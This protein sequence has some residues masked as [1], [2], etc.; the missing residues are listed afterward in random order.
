[1]IKQ[2]NILA[3]LCFILLSG[4]S[5]AKRLADGKPLIP[6]EPHHILKQSKKAVLDWDWIG[7]KMNADVKA[8]GTSED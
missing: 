6:R 7:F 5:N 3:I 2:I 8:N 4:C 1:M